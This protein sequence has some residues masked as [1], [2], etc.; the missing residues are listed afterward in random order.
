[1]LIKNSEELFFQYENYETIVLGRNAIELLLD[2]LSTS[3]GHEEYSTMLA[4]RMCGVE[5]WSSIEESYRF[6]YR[7]PG[8]FE[9]QYLI[10]VNQGVNI[11]ERIIEKLKRKYN[12]FELKTNNNALYTI[13]HKDQ[14]SI[15]KLKC[16]LFELDADE[17]PIL[18]C[19]L[20]NENFFL[21]TTKGMYSVFSNKQYIMYYKDFDRSDRSYYNSSKQ[22]GEGN[23]RVF[24]YYSKTNEIFIYEIDSL[25][26]ADA[27][28][29]VILHELTIRISKYK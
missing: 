15:L 29:N 25:Y 8:E 7:L 21:M 2:N 9:F 3:T 10:A 5:I 6:K 23:T 16:S 22:L 14:E 1:M 24:K 26:P 19:L 17:I 27:S 13:I 20:P 4:L 12:G 11:H 18:S 28:H